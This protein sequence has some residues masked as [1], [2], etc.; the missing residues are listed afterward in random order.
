M[1]DVAPQ[2]PDNLNAL[3]GS[4][5]E[6]WERADDLQVNQPV[7][8]RRGSKKDPT[9]GLNPGGMRPGDLLQ[10]VDRPH[11]DDPVGVAGERR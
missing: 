4:P 6:E 3:G 2:H 11:G 1:P 8:A 5:S 7:I 9:M 10:E